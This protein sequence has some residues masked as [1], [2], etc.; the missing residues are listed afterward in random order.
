MDQLTNGLQGIELQPYFIQKKK[1]RN[2]FI[3]E[4][5]E[6]YKIII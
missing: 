2:V 3:K 5:K 4:M 6:K 1:I